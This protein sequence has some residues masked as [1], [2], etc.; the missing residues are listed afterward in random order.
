VRGIF[1]QDSRFETSLSLSGNPPVDNDAT[2][3][4]GMPDL[5]AIGEIGPAIKWYFL[6]RDPLDKLY[7]QASAQA[8]ASVSFDSGPQ[9]VYRG[10]VGGLDLVYMNRSRFR[11][12]HL[13]FRVAAGV[14]LGDQGYHG[15]FYDVAPTYATPG[16][17]AY[18]AESGYGGTSLSFSM[19]YD[20]TPA[21]SL[22]FYSRW[23]NC[24]G[25]VFTDSPLVRQEQNFT[26]GVALIARALA[27]DTRV[28]AGE[29]D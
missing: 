5:D 13:R 28:P 15:Y 7:L 18:S 20:M 6:G 23:G 16:R 9:V 25:A 26:V 19:Q 2:A 10:I 17:P 11:D 27:S 12:Q 3:R 24:A 29:L 22:G 1:Y 4:E 14:N 21:L 8:A